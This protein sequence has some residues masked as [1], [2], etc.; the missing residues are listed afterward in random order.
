MKR[1]LIALLLA[2]L[3]AVSENNCLAIFIPVDVT[4][5][6]DGKQSHY[7]ELIQ[8]IRQG[9]SVEMIKLEKS[10]GMINCN[11]TV[12]EGTVTSWASPATARCIFETPTGTMLLNITFTLIQGQASLAIENLTGSSTSTSILSGKTIN[13]VYSISKK[14]SHIIEI[15]WP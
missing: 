15:E 13:K 12:T 10:I 7:V 2:I 8:I 14:R 5:T 9:N 4:E 1:I 6:F 3:I 11:A